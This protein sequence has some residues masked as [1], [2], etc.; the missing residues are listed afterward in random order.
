MRLYDSFASQVWQ[1]ESSLEVSERD[2]DAFV[3]EKLE[4]NFEFFNSVA[5]LID[6][7]RRLQTVFASDDLFSWHRGK[8]K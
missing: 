5:S 8:D 1:D 6:N 3:K 7:L 4:N 2:K